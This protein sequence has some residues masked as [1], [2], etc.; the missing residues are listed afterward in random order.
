MCTTDA[1]EVMGRFTAACKAA[2]LMTEII[3]RSTRVRVFQSAA[4]SSLAEVITLRPGHGNA[5]YAFWSWGDAIGPM[6]DLD[7]LVK[8]IAYVVK[9]DQ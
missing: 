1:H 6:S 9:G 7:V 2:G 5:L 4:H 8:T 3:E